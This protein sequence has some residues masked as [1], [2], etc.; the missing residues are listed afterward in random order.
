MRLGIIV[1]SE[2]RGLGSLSRDFHANLHPDKTLVV[3]PANARRHGLESHLDWYLDAELVR[4]DGR[5]HERTCREWLDG[6]DVVLSFETFYDWRFCQW[7]RDAHVATVCYAM[8]E[9]WRPAWALH[10]TQWWAPTSWRMNYLPPS[11]RLVPIP[12]PEPHIQKARIVPEDSPFRWLHPGGA[13]LPDERTNADRNGTQTVLKA[14]QLVREPQEIVVRT[15][16][17]LAPQEGVTVLEGNVENRWD[18]YGDADAVLLPRRYAGLSLPV[19][20]AFA[21]GLPVVMTDMSPQNSDWPVQTVPTSP[22][23]AHHLFGTTIETGDA[24]PHALAWFMDF[25]ATNPDEVEKWRSQSV[26]YATA[27]SWAVRGPEILAELEQT[28]AVV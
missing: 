9:W 5:L 10:P 15:Q 25:W 26:D 12:V 24:D 14:A 4:F 27:N 13:R 20:E 1:R 16:S 6:L 8:P 3:I 7:A 2:D 21:V 11:T 18:I 22:G 19:L 28:L 17:P 23:P